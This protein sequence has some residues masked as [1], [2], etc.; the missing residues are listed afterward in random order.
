[1]LHIHSPGSLW[2]VHTIGS[3]LVTLCVIHCLRFVTLSPFR[4]SPL[5]HTHLTLTLHRFCRSAHFVF[6]PAVCIVSW[7]FSFRLRFRF[8]LRYFHF[9]GH[10]LRLVYAKFSLV[11][12]HGFLS[13]MGSRFAVHGLPRC[14]ISFLVYV[15]SPRLRLRLAV[16]SFSRLAWFTFVHFASFHAYFA[17]FRHSFGWFTSLTAL[18]RIAH[19]FLVRSFSA[20]F[21]HSFIFLAAY[22]TLDFARVGTLVAPGSVADA[23]SHVHGF[24]RL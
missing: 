5:T 16:A 2:F 4:F 12:A 21:L 3:L 23:R 6:F 19:S 24:F 10:R 20:H 18:A 13:F 9:H 11:L 7:F 17:W 8:G 14:R 15:R 22:H 1:L